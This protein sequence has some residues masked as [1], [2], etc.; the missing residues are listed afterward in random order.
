M[1]VS[2]LLY[3]VRHVWQHHRKPL[4]WL[5]VGFVLPWFVFVRL[6][7][8][9]W[10]D[11]GLPGDHSILEFLHAHATP[12]LDALAVGLSRAGGPLGAS[13]LAGAI[14]LGLLLAGPR[15]ALAFFGLAVG[16][17]QLLNL[18]AKYLLLRTRPSL[19]VSLAPETSYSFPSGHTMAA[20]ALAAAVGFLLWRTRW[21]WPAVAVGL[22][23]AVG[24]GWSRMYLGVHYP[25]DVLAGWVGSVG[26]VGGLHLLFSRYFREL[27]VVWHEWENRAL[28][29]PLDA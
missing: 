18:S 7:R 8:E 27:G 16:G 20:A 12:A 22:L 21:R 24:M 15:R 9:V 6:A 17:A 29:R 4:A 19:W 13:L 1:S 5:L 3:F 2:P 23:W 28:R 25:S 14:W 10:E 26:W 11:E